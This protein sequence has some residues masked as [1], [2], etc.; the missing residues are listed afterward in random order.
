MAKNNDGLE[1]ELA[2]V[3]AEI[4]DNMDYETKM[5][6]YAE[7]ISRKLPNGKYKVVV[8]AFVGVVFGLAYGARLISQVVKRRFKK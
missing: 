6:L 7:Q 4:V 5:I 1:D 3:V 8:G 2:D